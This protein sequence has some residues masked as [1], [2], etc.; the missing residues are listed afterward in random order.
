MKINSEF[1]EL[2]QA[3]NDE[4]ARYLV[5]GAHAVAYH[6]RPRATNDFDVWVANDAE[7]ARRIYRALATF[8]APLERLTVED[9]VSDG[10]IFQIGVAPI[11]I[12]VITSVSGVS[13]EE[14]WPSRVGF[15]FAGVAANVIGRAELIR[16]KRA[17]GRL[18]DLADIERLEHDG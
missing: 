2:L 17:A 11:R 5:V 14:A 6:A 10:L 4:N 1:V 7:N 16:N 15:D 12:D 13:F 18:K 9:L 3:F 8:G